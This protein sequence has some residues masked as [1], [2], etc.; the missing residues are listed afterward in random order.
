MGSIVSIRARLHLVRIEMVMNSITLIAQNY[1]FILERRKFQRPKGGSKNIY[2]ISLQRPLEF[3]EAT[4]LEVINTLKTFNG[5]EYGSMLHFHT[6]SYMFRKRA[7]AEKAW[8]FVM[9]RWA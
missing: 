4:L 5:K 7:D 3:N 2:V 8:V 9:L 6:Y 1:R